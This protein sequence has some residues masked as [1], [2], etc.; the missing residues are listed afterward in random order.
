MHSRKWTL[1]WQNRNIMEWFS[2]GM[3]KATQSDES[4]IYNKVANIRVQRNPNDIIATF[5]GGGFYKRHGEWQKADVFEPGMGWKIVVKTFLYKNAFQ[6]ADE[7]LVFGDGGYIAMQMRTLGAYGIQTVD[8]IWVNI[9]N[10]GFDPAYPVYDGQPLFSINHPYKGTGGVFANRPAT[11]SDLTQDSLL[12]GMNYFLNMRTDDGMAFS[13]TPKFLIVHTS[14]YYQAIRM[15]SIPTQLGQANPAIPNVLFGTPY[16]GLT[17]LTSA[18]LTD[19]NAW[20]LLA[21]RSEVSGMGHG[22]DLWFTPNGQPSTKTVRLE[23]PDAYK[24][25]GKLRAGTVV[26]KVRGAWGNPGAT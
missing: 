21:D 11:G 15:L 16:G 13:M 5:W 14:Q 8:N 12:E 18:K 22:L 6:V 24:Y 9:L 10:N 19:T 3:S 20:F 7:N 25:I 4:L 17:V 26:T 1:D 23:D 2:E